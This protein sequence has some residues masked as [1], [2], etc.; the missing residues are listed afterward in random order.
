MP[1]G[2]VDD[3]QLATLYSG[4]HAFVFPSRYEGFGLPV[5]EARACGAAVLASD[6]PEIREAGGEDALYVPP[7][8]EGLR[9]G[10]RGVIARSRPPALASGLLPTWQGSA[11]IVA[12]YLRGT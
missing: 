4:C 9:E 11:A 5:L 1:L 10:L 8:A 6:L 12:R 7:T 2:F 3:D